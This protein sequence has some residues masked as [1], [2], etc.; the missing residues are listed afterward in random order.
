[1][2]KLYT[3]WYKY[4]IYH[5]DAEGPQTLLKSVEKSN[6]FQLYYYLR[7]TLPSQCYNV[8]VNLHG[9]IPFSELKRRV[10]LGLEKRRIR[11]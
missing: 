9:Y 10:M 6:I 8:M 2:R 1:M 4:T 7:R 5:V 3:F 11:L